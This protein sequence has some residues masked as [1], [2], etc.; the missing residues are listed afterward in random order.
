[1]IYIL[2]KKFMGRISWVHELEMGG[3]KKHIF[4]FLNLELKFNIS[5]YKCRQQTA[6]VI[7]NTCY[8][9]RCYRYFYISYILNYCLHSHYFGI[10]VDISLTTRSCIEKMVCHYISIFEKNWQLHFNRVGFLRL[11][12]TAKRLHKNC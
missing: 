7:S 4:I 10:M 3:E 11:Y 9:D 2:P 12:H 8:S 5:N 6:M 1:M